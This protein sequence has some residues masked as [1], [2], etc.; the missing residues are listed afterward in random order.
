MLVWLPPGYDDPAYANKVY[1]VLYLMDGQNVFQKPAGVPGE[2]GADETAQRLVSGGSAEP[3]IIVA[4][5]STPESR[6][7]EYLPVAAL[8]GVEPAGDAFVRWLVTRVK[9]RVDR[10]FRADPRA[11][12]T[13]IGGSSLGGVIALHAGTRRPDVFG[14]VLAESPSIR[15]GDAGLWKAWESGVKSWPRRIYLGVGDQEY[16]TG[17][18]AADKS[19]ALVRA[20]NELRARIVG[21]GVDE[22]RVR[23]VVGAGQSHN[24]EAWAKRFE[25][26]ARF[27]F[28]A[29]EASTGK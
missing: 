20:V 17:A 14:M 12:R 16:G 9:P 19:A 13:A 18:G 29:S 27:L 22:S 7:Q 25:G 10:A 8:E 1:P 5:P 4:V 24:E 2:W 15:A 11:E 26:A 23:V 6:V 3:F 28:P 21:S